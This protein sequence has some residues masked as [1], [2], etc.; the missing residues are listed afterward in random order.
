[1]KSGFHYLQLITSGKFQKFDYGESK[2]LIYYGQSTPPP[3]N[4]SNIIMPVFIHY[5]DDDIFNELE[6]VEVAFKLL[7]NVVGLNKIH[8]YG[9]YDFIGNQHVAKKVYIKI[10]ENLNKYNRK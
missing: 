10:V 8:K 4:T 5:G 9:H 1:M 3:Y 6:D 7:P 2:N